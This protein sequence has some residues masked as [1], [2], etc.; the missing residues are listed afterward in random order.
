MENDLR[1]MC[2]PIN[3]KEIINIIQKYGNLMKFL[4]KAPKTDALWIKEVIS[5]NEI[6]FQFSLEELKKHRDYILNKIQKYPYLLYWVPESWSN[7]IE[8]VRQT[9]KC[10]KS[11]LN[12]ASEE[13]RNNSEFLLEAVQL[14]GLA[15]KFAS[16][17]LKN[18][19]KIV[20]KAIENDFWAFMYASPEC[21]N[22]KEIFLKAIQMEKKFITPKKRFYASMNFRDILL[23]YASDFLKQTNIVLGSIRNNPYSIRCIPLPFRNKRKIVKKAFNGRMRTLG[24]TPVYDYDRYFILT[25]KYHEK[26]QDVKDHLNHF[27]YLLTV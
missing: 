22:N 8:I 13:L 7:D 4:S 23:F 11:F 5:C 19:K 1:D 16:E 6:L 9:L 26:D 24:Y 18:D 2:E 17:D 15:L 27:G 12:Y 14:N 3:E 10:E 20:I 21:R 25:M